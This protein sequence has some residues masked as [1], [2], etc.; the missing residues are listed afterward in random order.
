MKVNIIGAGLAGLS[1][2]ITLAKKGIPCNLV[3]LLPSERAQS[4]LAEGGINGALNTMGEGDTPAEH[5]EDTIRAGVYLADENAVRNLTE[6]APEIL[7]E[8][9]DLGVPFHLENERIIQRNFGGQKK[10]RTAYA[11]SSTGKVLMTA[12]IDETRKY[13]VRGL[14]T[15]YPHHE[16]EDLLTEELSANSKSSC[17]GALIRDHYTEEAIVL[18]GPVILATGGMNGLFPGETTGTV[19]NSSDAAALVFSKGVRFSN[20]EMIQYHPTTIRIPGK[21]CLISEAARGEGGRLFTL[22]GGNPWYFMEEKYPELGNLMPRDVVSREMYF[23]AHDPNCCGQ[24]WLDLR[25]LAGE[26]WRKKLP[27]LREEVIHYLGI[28]PAKTPV[29]VEPGIHYFM[30]GID[31][32]ISHRTSFRNLFAAGECCSQYH[33]ANRLG[34]NSTMGAIYGGK[35]AAQSAAKALAECSGK[36]SGMQ[37]QQ[38]VKEGKGLVPVSEEAAQQISKLLLGALGI[39]RTEADLE[40]AIGE[41]DRML[42]GRKDR[43]GDCTDFRELPA[44]HSSNPKELRRLL[45]AKAL[46][47][48]ASCRK[49]SR[50][51]HYRSDYPETEDDFRTKMISYA[52]G[53]EVFA[54]PEQELPPG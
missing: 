3:S 29:P 7:R 1:A 19:T 31:V 2:A 12:L 54:A 27:D 9:R 21:R 34:G 24:V 44:A 8:L 37:A 20:L 15:R 5:F 50:G 53:A 52:A 38:T 48:S 25:H 33:G 16:L 41:I 10:K 13:E 17:C 4:V 30:G 32:D 39:V 6:Q 51:A 36:I 42:S 47:L 22:R 45:L 14:V 26:T 18:Q 35:V 23:V 43:S 49:E 40:A 46:L 11:R 28:D